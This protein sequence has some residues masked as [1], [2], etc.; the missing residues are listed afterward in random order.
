M[1]DHRRQGAPNKSSRQGPGRTGGENASE[2]PGKSPGAKRFDAPKPGGK[3]ASKGFPKDRVKAA[4]ASTAGEVRTDGHKSAPRA[5]PRAAAAA[6]DVRSDRLMQGKPRTRPER[7]RDERPRD[8]RPIDERPIDER[9]R[10]ERPRAER[11]REER[12]KAEHGRGNPSKVAAGIVARPPVDRPDPS[13]PVYDFNPAGVADGAA[14][15]RVAKALARAGVASRR[16][17][18]RYIADGRVAVNGKVLETPATKIEAG[19]VL[20]VDGKVINEAEP[21][22]LWRYH[23]PVGLLTTHNDPNGRATVFENLP[24]ELPR[25][26]SVGRLDLASE[27]LLLLTNDGS[28]ARALEMPKSGWIRRYR[29]RAF[30]RTSQVKLDELAKGVTVEGVVYGPIEAKLDKV[31]RTESVGGS[32][33]WI[34]VAIAEGKNREVRRVLE[35]VGLK[36]NRLIRLAYG[37]FALGTLPQASVEEVGPR[38]IRE[39]LAGFIA[40]ENM[41]KGD[42]PAGEILMAPGANRFRRMPDKPGSPKAEAAAAAKAA[43]PEREKKVYKAGWAKPAKSAHP[44]HK[45]GP[46][47]PRTARGADPS[48]FGIVDKPAS[49]QARSPARPG[50]APPKGPSRRKP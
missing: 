31:A 28:L 25:V 20:T 35:S 40:P 16:E 27:G 44:V 30:G 3:S 15:E 43:P 14:G 10:A 12:P 17:V 24:P 1:V 39:L 34:T 45:A 50:K 38:V 23:K 42:R 18:E 47:K 46:K 6:S 49:G 13:I 9:P 11:T 5:G 41:P 26:I 8:E 21:T 29:V 4:A 7:P 32:N 22:R 37:P 19:D 48:A 2:T 33:V 36:V